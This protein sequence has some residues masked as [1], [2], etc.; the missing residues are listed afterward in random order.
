MICENLRTPWLRSVLSLSW[1]DRYR[2]KTTFQI[3]FHETRFS[4][5]QSHRT[6]NCVNWTLNTEFV[7]Q[8]DSRASLNKRRGRERRETLFT[9]FPTVEQLLG[10]SRALC[11]QS[12]TRSQTENK[13]LKFFQAKSLQYFSINIYF[14]PIGV[15]RESNDATKWLFHYS[16]ILLKI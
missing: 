5:A 13:Q 12:L 9:S 1:S 14:D 11:A 2:T 7:W 4:P 10:Y 3:H 16:F 6:L 15:S 8:C